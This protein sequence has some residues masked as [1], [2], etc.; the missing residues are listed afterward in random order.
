MAIKCEVIV[1]YMDGKGEPLLFFPQQRVNY[2]NIGYYY[3][4]PM[5]AGH[6]EM[7]IMCFWKRYKK[8]K[9]GEQEE[10]AVKAIEGYMKFYNDGSEDDVELVRKYKVTD[11]NREQMWNRRKNNG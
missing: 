8:P 1:K 9:A 7:D 11:K 2:G 3:N 5:E 4:D 10:K 6:S